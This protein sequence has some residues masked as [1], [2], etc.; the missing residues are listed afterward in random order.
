MF[1]AFAGFAVLFVVSSTTFAQVL[2]LPVR[3][4]HV[5][6]YGQVYYYGGNDSRVHA[7][8]KSGCAHYGYATNLHRF[9]GGNSFGQPSPMYDDTPV[10]TDCIPGR[11][12]RW[13]GYTA[14]DAHNE[15]ASNVARYFRKADQLAGGIVM[16]DG[17][18]VVPP[19]P[20]PV[21]VGSVPMN[22]YS[23][24]QPSTKRG[25][26]III[27]KN[28]LDKKVKDLDKAPQKVALA[29]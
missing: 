23:V 28:L 14:A 7:Y 27:P 22:K 15:A 25:N 4:Q 6:S 19:T 20:S 3:S 16:S 26:V 11:D 12:A 10:F 5:D 2:Y 8:M 17:A 1:R 24:T 18:L 13:F 21:Y 9:D 29:Q